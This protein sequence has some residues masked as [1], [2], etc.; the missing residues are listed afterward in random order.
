MPNYNT[1]ICIELFNSTRKY[2]PCQS[3]RNNPS[4]MFEFEDGIPWG[5]IVGLVGAVVAA[6]AAVGFV[7]SKIMMK[8]GHQDV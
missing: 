2:Q 7:I 5:V 4:K 8:D 3:V 1:S 6:L